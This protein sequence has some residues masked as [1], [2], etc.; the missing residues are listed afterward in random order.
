VRSVKF[1]TESRLLLLYNSP[2]FYGI[3][4]IMNI[5]SFFL[6]KTRSQKR[7]YLLALDALL[8]SFVI[9]SSFSL[10]ANKVFIPSGI[11]WFTFPLAFLISLPIFIR[12]GLY[13]AV[14]QYFRG[15]AVI[16]IF[17]ATLL[18]TMVWVGAVSLL[19]IIELSPMTVIVY[20]LGVFMLVTVVRLGA[21]HLLYS[22]SQEK[23]GRR[24]L[25]YGAG[26]AGTQLTNILK[27]DSSY[28]VSGFIDDDKSLA[29]WD[30][31]GLKVFSSIDLAN[32]IKNKN[33]DEIILA[34]PSIGRSKR[35]VIINRLEPLPVNIRSI[36]PFLDLAHGKL[37]VSDIKDI[38]IDDLLGREV[39]EPD[40]NLLPA[41]IKNKVVMVTGAGG[42][43]GSELCRQII[44]LSPKK[45]ILLEQSEFAL[46]QI[47][48]E[49]EHIVLSGRLS[50]ELDKVLGSITNATL[51][52]RLFADKTIN[53]IYHAAAYKHVPLVEENPVAGLSNNVFGTRFLA[54]HASNADVETFI[55]ISTDKA[56]RPT[57]V[58]GCSKRISELVLQGLS[59]KIDCKTVF[60]M[61]RF[62]NV[63]G[64]SGSVVPKFRQQ[65]RDGGPITVTHKE[66]TRFFMSIPEAVQLVI[67]AGAMAKGGEV[68]VLDMGESV[69]IVE[70]AKRMIKLA[71]LNIRDEKN[72]EGDIEIEYSGLRPGEKLYE[73]LLIG[74]N[75]S[76]TQ[77]KRI[78]KAN[79]VYISWSE[80]QEHL[81]TLQEIMMSD[82]SDKIKSNLA[83]F[84][85]G[86]TPWIKQS[87]TDKKTN[88]I[89]IHS[90]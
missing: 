66:I 1:L 77:H 47:E 32:I 38:D 33:I 80:L 8:I 7:I 89:N 86:Y 16:A 44:Q 14:L 53:T 62:G 79:E 6:Q 56:V 84:V 36:P 41:N 4:L 54:E 34:M 48:Q 85:D 52:K 68:F 22:L 63:L 15:K 9:W 20:W 42:S 65:I 81:S 64:S 51:L 11:E 3:A 59:E 46:Y 61:V 45:L 27:S 17:L 19:K 55:L 70:L 76:G 21:Q 78:M 60:S 49:L 58:M 37:S 26:A 69:K 50:I 13:R 29:G 88:I 40:S 57:N 71:G 72:P 24:V 90:N 39:I 74:D 28:S 30:I 25:I 43:I 67:Q 18:S 10:Q 87:I 5:K 31:L 12:L 83:S 2:L 75:V 23:T 35:Q 73:E 82:N